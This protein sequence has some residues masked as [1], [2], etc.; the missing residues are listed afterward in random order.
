LFDLGAT[1]IEEKLLLRFTDLYK[2]SSLTEFKGF[3][4]S[5]LQALQN[6]IFGF[7]PQAFAEP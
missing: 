3:E 7:L 1:G 5:L 6:R 4:I 2:S